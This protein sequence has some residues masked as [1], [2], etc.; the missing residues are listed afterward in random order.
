MAERLGIKIIPRSYPPRDM[1]TSSRGGPTVGFHLQVARSEEGPDFFSRPE[2]EKRLSDLNWKEGFLGYF[3][4][5]LDPSSKTLLFHTY[6]PLCEDPKGKLKKLGIAAEAELIALRNLQERY[7][8]W[9]IGHDSVEGSVSFE[10]RKHLSR[11]GLGM[12]FLRTLPIGERI[13]RIEKFLEKQAKPEAHEGW[14]NKFKKV[15]GLPA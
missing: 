15:V 7:A 3:N 4:F 14:W 10:R 5:D 6:D 13:R 11:M 12:F 8:D 1:L 9:K 2:L